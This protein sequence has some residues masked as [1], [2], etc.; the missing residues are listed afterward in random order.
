MLDSE[1][2]IL[3]ER[4]DE[5]EKRLRALEGLRPRDMHIMRSMEEFRLEMLA[6]NS[7]P[8]NYDEFHWFLPREA[9]YN[10]TDEAIERGLLTQMAIGTKANIRSLTSIKLTFN[11][12]R[13]D[14]MS[15]T[16]GRHDRVKT[17][18]L[19][20]RVDKITACAYKDATTFLMFNDDA[21]LSWGAQ[22]TDV[23]RQANEIE[24]KFKRTQ[25]IVG[26]Y[27]Y[28]M[29]NDYDIVWR[30]SFILNNDF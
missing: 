8:E 17:D 1:N 30:F 11:N 29:Q 18:E 16:F 22:Q 19:N 24:C 14:Y 21:R 28:K 12:G 4:C 9:L 27:G 6:E 20:G 7:H 2:Q 23:M 15:P 10:A 26:F 3:R 13:K 5:Y 25:Q